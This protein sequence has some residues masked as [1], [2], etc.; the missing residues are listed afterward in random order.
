MSDDLLMKLEDAVRAKAREG[1]ILGYSMTSR[2]VPDVGHIYC[3]AVPVS[4]S[5]MFLAIR[6]QLDGAV[7][8]RAALVEKLAA[9]QR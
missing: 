8:S 1:D 7:I 5:T 6:W 2:V 4:G 3:C 9:A